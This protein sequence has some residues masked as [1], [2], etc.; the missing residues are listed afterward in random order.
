MTFHRQSSQL[1]DSILLIDIS[2]PC[3]PRRSG[4]TAWPN[5]C[6]CCDSF[7][8]TFPL[9]ENSQFLQCSGFLFFPFSVSGSRP[10]TIISKLIHINNHKNTDNSSNLLYVGRILIATDWG[11]IKKKHLFVPPDSLSS[12]RCCSSERGF[13]RLCCCYCCSRASCL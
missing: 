5:L 2:S 12:C 13:S 9:V 7:L 4:S 10:S 8:Q 1:H 6:F 11:S 3:P